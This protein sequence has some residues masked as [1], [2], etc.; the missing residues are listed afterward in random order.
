ML[1]VLSSCVPQENGLIL[2]VSICVY[3]GRERLQQ[4]GS[5]LIIMYLLLLFQWLLQLSNFITTSFLLFSY[6]APFSLPWYQRYKINTIYVSFSCLDDM[7]LYFIIWEEE[8]CCSLSCSYRVN[9]FSFS[10]SNFEIVS[11]K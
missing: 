2:F 8:C 9:S 3:G 11:V 5:M 10:S 7:E 6:H 1:K 4:S